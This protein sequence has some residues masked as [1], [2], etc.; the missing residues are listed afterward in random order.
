[1]SLQADLK[2]R[3]PRIASLLRG[4]Y[5]EGKAEVGIFNTAGISAVHS[6]TVTSFSLACVA[7]VQGETQI[8]YAYHGSRHY[9][10]LKT[11]W[12]IERAVAQ[13]VSL[14]GGRRIDS[15]RYDLVL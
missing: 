6:S 9:A 11:P 8:G 3:D 1:E 2:R 15:G 5:R 12:V 10:D 14:L 13:G 7:A 4:S